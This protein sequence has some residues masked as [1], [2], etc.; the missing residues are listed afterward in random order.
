[1]AGREGG[2]EIRS[3]RPRGKRGKRNEKKN[4][5]GG[6]EGQ[7]S[8]R[9]NMRPRMREGGGREKEIK[10]EPRERDIPALGH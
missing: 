3:S 4:Q 6:K 2:K 8:R 10:T 5:H 1:M 7:E 9:M